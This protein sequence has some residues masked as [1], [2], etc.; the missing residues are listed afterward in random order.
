MY[1]FLDLDTYHIDSEGYLLDSSCRYIVDH[2]GK[3]IKLENKH[4]EILKNN[5]VLK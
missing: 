3:K 2:K 1:I 5:G 4:L